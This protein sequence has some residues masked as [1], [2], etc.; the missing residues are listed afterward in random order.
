[1][2]KTKSIDELLQERTVAALKKHD[3]T[4]RQ[5]IVA[6]AKKMGYAI[7]AGDIKKIEFLKFA[8]LEQAVKPTFGDFVTK[9][10]KQPTF[11]D[12]AEIHNNSPGTIERTV[13]YGEKESRQFTW[14]ITTGV[15]VGASVSEKVAIP[16]LSSEVTLNMQMSVSATSGVAWH[17][18]KDWASTTKVTVPPH[19]TVNM[20]AL[21]VRVLGNLPFVLQ[22]SKT[23]NAR[24]QVTLSYHGTRTRTFDVDLKKLLSVADRTFKVSGRISGAC[25][26]SCYINANGKKLKGASKLSLP[27]GVSTVPSSF[28]TL[29]L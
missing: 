2:A 14:S 25:G 24:C 28:G 11:I 19:S 18:E 26:V 12:T 5:K 23:G 1:M 29:R 16:G 20:Q 9:E 27:E 22:V 6:E 8:G 7:S 15:T 3:K 13:H 21:L 17:D 4:I 10:I